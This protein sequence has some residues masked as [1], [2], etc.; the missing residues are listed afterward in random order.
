MSWALAGQVVQSVLVPAT[1][2]PHSA[3][4]GIQFATSVLVQNVSEHFHSFIT[5]ETSSAFV[6]HALQSVAAA[7]IQ[8]HHVRSQGDQ[9]ATLV[10]GQKLSAHYQ[11][12]PTPADSTAS[13]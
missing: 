6:Q 11:A 3:E 10:F 2:L 12:L 5:P 9:L 13:A 1:Q 7:E 4:H 8:F